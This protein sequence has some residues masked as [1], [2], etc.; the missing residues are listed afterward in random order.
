MLHLYFN[1]FPVLETERLTLHNLS[2]ENAGDMFLIRGNP[3]AMK[4]IGKPLLKSISD[5]EQLIE[6]YRLNVAHHVSINWGITLKSEN[7]GMVGVIGYHR[8]EKENFRA[9]IGYVLHP[10]QWYKGIMNEALTCVL[11]Y[12]FN[13]LGLHSVEARVNP[14]NHQS[15][16]ILL[17]NG[18]VKE[19]YFKESYFSEGQFLDTEVY[20]LI[21]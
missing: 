17:K 10:N 14:E 7:A 15:S 9:E 16:K 6:M 5:A 20:S 12:G 18:F 11:N 4:F 21:R 3:V 13:D 2:S 1:P 19:A 8:V